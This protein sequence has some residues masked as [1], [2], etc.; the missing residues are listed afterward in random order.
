[1]V[2]RLLYR[3]LGD[4]MLAY[5]GVVG[6]A[7]ASVA[8]PDHRRRSLIRV[9][10][11]HSSFLIHGLASA[12][13]SRV[14][15]SIITALREVM[16]LT[17]LSRLACPVRRA[18]DYL[19]LSRLCIHDTP[20]CGEVCCMQNGCR[21]HARGVFA[22]Q[23]Q[24]MV[25]TN[26]VRMVHVGKGRLRGCA[27]GGVCMVRVLGEAF[28]ANEARKPKQLTFRKPNGKAGGMM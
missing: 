26:M 7:V 4:C 24:S 16:P 27:T 6:S 9:Y 5:V 8:W 22:C 21:M 3:P 14:V 11:F 17:M 19:M 2:T 1:M 10:G 23:S 13:R 12:L 28:H 20:N 25:L 18:V 15:R